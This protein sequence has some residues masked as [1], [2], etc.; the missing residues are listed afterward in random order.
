MSGPLNYNFQSLSNKI[1]P[2][3]FLKFN[4]SHFSA[5]VKLFFFFCRKRKP[6]IVGFE[7]VM[8]RGI[9]KIVIFE[10]LYMAYGICLQHVNG[11]FKIKCLGR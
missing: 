7:N 8:E 11:K 3:D 6:K 9:R 4:F 10:K 5:Q 2:Y 1:I